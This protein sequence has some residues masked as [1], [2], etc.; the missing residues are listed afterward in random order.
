[1]RR[2]QKFITTS[3]EIVRH[4][5]GLTEANFNLMTKL[6]HWLHANESAQRKF[7]MAVIAKLCRLQAQITSLYPPILAQNQRLQLIDGE[8]LMADAKAIEEFITKNERETI[9]GIMEYIYREEPKAEG[10]H[11]RRKK[12]HGWEI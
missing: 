5:H 1:M 6:I 10:R 2:N 3:P 11:N 7:R 8:K 4:I 12:W 9:V